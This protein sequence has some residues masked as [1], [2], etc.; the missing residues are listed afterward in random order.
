[1]SNNK[2]IEAIGID[3]PAG[4]GKSTIAREVAKKLDFTYI[5]TGAMYRAV[6]LQACREKVDLEDEK[7]MIRIAS[8][9]DINFDATGTI[10][11]LNSED[12]SSL[13]RS[14]EITGNTKFAARV[15][16]VRGLLVKRQQQMAAK[17]R[18][19]MEGRDITTVVLP[20]AKWRIF[21]T[22]SPEVRAKRRLN[23]FAQ[24]G[25]TVDYD[26][27]LCEII[28]RDESDNAV[29]PMKEAQELARAGKGIY[30]LDTSELSQ[31]EV[32]DNIVQYVENY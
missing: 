15:T 11:Y 16:E 25:H 29:G 21:L 23:D 14:P 31:Q 19:V 22:A 18:V 32:I 5:D 27:L 2:L 6:A 26:K 12:V 8:E 3:G 30:L 28:A 17:R 7:E 1:M 4:S 10:I 24:R 9:I 20:N 13:I